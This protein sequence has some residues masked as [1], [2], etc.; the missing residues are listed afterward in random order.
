MNATAVLRELYKDAHARLEQTMD[1]VTAEQAHWPPPG[2]T[3]P[4]GP[5]YVHVLVGEDFIINAILQNQPPR[6]TATWLG[7]AGF[8]EPPP[9]GP[10]WA[11]WSRRVQVDLETVRSYARDVY[12]A[13]DEYLASI[14]DS[15]L[16]RER[17]FMRSG[18]QTA[19]Q[20]LSDL[21]AHIHEHCGEI[22]CLKG[23]QGARG[24]PD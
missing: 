18:R 5:G 19:S 22:A 4:I 24:Y 14:D 11:E 16:D 6:L 8:S 1:G 15:E 3:N 7:K 2:N 21:V 9:A 23:L 10:E 12:A 13:A 20:I 17:Q